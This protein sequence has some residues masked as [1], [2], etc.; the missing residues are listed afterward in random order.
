M[1]PV[2]GTGGWVRGE[3]SMPIPCKCVCHAQRLSQA[4]VLY[5]AC[6]TRKMGQM[7]STLCSTII[8]ASCDIIIILSQFSSV[9][10]HLQS[11][12]WNIVHTDSCIMSATS[13]AYATVCLSVCLLVCSFTCSV[14]LFVCL[15]IYLSVCG[16][17]GETDDTAQP[18][19]EQSKKD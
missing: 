9:L 13:R 4:G 14:C 7:P 5:L 1:M 6:S 8:S 17:I 2:A 19:G 11:Q 3:T 12:L 18:L 15:S 16:R 10:S